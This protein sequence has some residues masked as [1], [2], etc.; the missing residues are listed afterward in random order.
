MAVGPMREYAIVEHAQNLERENIAM[1]EAL[2]KIERH[3]PIMGS[4][5]DYR[6]GQLDILET[7]ST[8]AGLALCANTEVI[9]GEKGATK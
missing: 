5:G 6:Q 7:V 9:H 2:E 1:R 4:T 8:I 3:G